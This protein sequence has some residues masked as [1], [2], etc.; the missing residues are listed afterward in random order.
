MSGNCLFSPINIHGS[1]MK[2][3][4]LDIIDL[5]CDSDDSSE[6]IAHTPSKRIKIEWIGSE[7]GWLMFKND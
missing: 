3:F 6:L 5:T 1:E 2:L 4:V 7:K